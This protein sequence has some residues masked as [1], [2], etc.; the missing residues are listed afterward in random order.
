MLPNDTT[1]EKAMVVPADLKHANSLINSPL[2][3]APVSSP[4]GVAQS[5][6]T[7]KPLPKGRSRSV[8]KDRDK[9]TDNV[10]ATV[11]ATLQLSTGGSSSDTRNTIVIRATFDDP[12]KIRKS[13]QEQ[14]DQA[15]GLYATFSGTP[16]AER[17]SAPDL[18]D[19]D[20]S[21]PFSQLH[22]SPATATSAAAQ[23]FT[24]PSSSG[25]LQPSLINRPL[26]EITYA[27]VDSMNPDDLDTL[28]E[29]IEE[30]LSNGKTTK[31]TRKEASQVQ[32]SLWEVE[33]KR[34]GVLARKIQSGNSILWRELAICCNAI[35][36]PHTLFKGILELIQKKARDIVN[37][38]AIASF[39]LFWVQQNRDTLW[40]HKSKETIRQI[41][42]AIDNF[43][44]KPPITP[45]PKTLRTYSQVAYDPNT[46]E[47][48]TEKTQKLLAETPPKQ[49]YTFPTLSS[50]EK[51]SAVPMK[52][53]ISALIKRADTQRPTEFKSPA[54][55]IACDLEQIQRLLLSQISPHHLIHSKWEKGAST[56]RVLYISYYTA[57][58]NFF[59]DQL[60]DG[61]T[62]KMIEKRFHFVVQIAYESLLLNDFSSALALLGAL[63]NSA[64]FRLTKECEN[65]QLRE[66]RRVLSSNGN[67]KIL[68]EKQ[69]E[70]KKNKIAYIPPICLLE[71][72]LEGARTSPSLVTREPGAVT[73]N[74]YK[75]DLFFHMIIDFLEPFKQTPAISFQSDIYSVI[76]QH[77]V[78]DD[79][80]L[81][82]RS[83]EI[84]PRAQQ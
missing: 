44:I 82:K 45:F 49:I 77:V 21:K 80:I 28:T 61:A 59:M 48:P 68:R 7:P 14:S 50:F 83:L 63:D 46:I 72:D 81:Y 22:I 67:F 51:S 33:L 71:Q 62:K 17:Q 74:Y 52:I 30:L 15:Q 38:E 78:K 79:E 6:H 43:K 9:D 75:L 19:E 64:I 13:V 35:L 65:N 53:D 25:N 36:T 40:M 31:S 60:L 1:G 58:S 24:P 12:R 69:A 11:S 66:L 57:L 2:A 4:T 39:C 47:N 76:T 56:A 18:H 27:A 55:K 10:I 41:C 54:K 16:A 8:P 5:T 3:A 42:E 70:C 84:S 32:E 26:S 20:I 37:T 23:S 34:I 73:F 29:R